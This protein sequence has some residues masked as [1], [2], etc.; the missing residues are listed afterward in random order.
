M[1]PLTLL[2]D[3]VAR[4][5]A[6]H[7][8][9]EHPTQGTAVLLTP[10]LAL[11]CAHCLGEEREHAKVVTL[12]L[13]LRE[14]PSI[15]QG[16]VLAQR[17]DWQRDAALLAVYPP[18]EGIQRLL[19]GRRPERGAR[20][21]SVLLPHG[22]DDGLTIRNG[23]VAESN[24]RLANRDM[25]ELE[26]DEA[27][28]HLAGASGGPILVGDR[29]VGLLSDQ[30]KR[31]SAINGF[32]P[33]FG[34]V[35]AIPIDTLSAW[36]ECAIEPSHSARERL[37][38]TL[39]GSPEELSEF[40]VAQILRILRDFSGDSRLVIER[41]L[42]GSIL[43]QI[44]ANKEAV[45][46]LLRL[47]ERGELD[48]IYDR[49]LLDVCVTEPSHRSPPAGGIPSSMR[50]VKNPLRS[51]PATLQWARKTLVDA[52]VDA[53]PQDVEI[54]M[55]LQDA[56]ISEADVAFG[57]T[58]KITWRNV[59]RVAHNAGLLGLLIREVLRDRS[60]SAYHAE[61]KE[62]W[63]E[64]L[65]DS[66]GPSNGD[67]RTA[68]GV[69]LEEHQDAINLD[70]WLDF[71]VPRGAQAPLD[72][73]RAN[74]HRLVDH[75]QEHQHLSAPALD[76]LIRQLSR[77]ERLMR[78]QVWE[79]LRHFPWQPHSS[80]PIPP[81]VDVHPREP[82]RPDVLAGPERT[83][84]LL[85]TQEWHIRLDR[86]HQWA[87]LTLACA[88]PR[89][90]RAFSLLARP[91]Q[92][93][94]WFCERIERFFNLSVG[95]RHRVLVVPIHP[96]DYRG[97]LVTGEDVGRRVA[98]QTTSADLGWTRALQD[99]LRQAPVLLVLGRPSI[100][101]ED[102]TLVEAVRQFLELLPQVEDPK[103]HP[104]RVLLLLQG[105][106]KPSRPLWRTLQQH[107]GS[108]ATL[109]QEMEIPPKAEVLTQLRNEQPPLD[110]AT[111]D[112]CLEA[113]DEVAASGVEDFES[114]AQALGGAIQQRLQR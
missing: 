92:R 84:P 19:L 16:T 68:L 26:L 12:E 100:E 25:L 57:P 53:Y 114:F 5:T 110:D 79:T 64:L 93:P 41:I 3:L 87:Q 35:Y 61:V 98:S 15:H 42:E 10:D 90:R 4:I 88:V 13:C 54:R 89:G 47:F 58:T 59:S 109:L 99:E 31:D 111:L 24:Y 56:G 107:W 113:Y 76:R 108:K 97:V 6:E 40:D 71:V 27:R 48:S 75:L 102:S 62:A 103:L 73:K 78:P 60:R 70:D 9:W 46:R 91:E 85:D 28:Y 11:T 72:S 18:V 66:P 101:L 44:R 106:E 51:S 104:L 32:S 52:L 77:K 14:T 80:R 30:L 22:V 86:V 105:A 36:S 74:P 2:R 65:G 69:L 1:D 49:R 21:G 29:I 43:L 8:H 55:L 17:L 81:R 7:P 33:S 96:G 34:R 94:H 83:Q 95:L 63:L 37:S 82:L 39:E 45:Q 23:G 67:A 20:W 50:A 112:L 38:I